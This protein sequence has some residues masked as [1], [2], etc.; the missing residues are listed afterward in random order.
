[1]EINKEKTRKAIVELINNRESREKNEEDFD[2]KATQ[3]DKHANTRWIKGKI[4][5]QGFD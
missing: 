3:D 2:V 1:M 5:L 4:F